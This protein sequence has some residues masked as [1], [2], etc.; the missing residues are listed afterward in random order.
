MVCISMSTRETTYKRS[1]EVKAEAVKNL[2]TLFSIHWGETSKKTP[3][4][5]ASEALIIISKA[6]DIIPL[7]KAVKES[8]RIC[9][10]VEWIE[11]NHKD[12]K[13]SKLSV[14]LIGNDMA[15]THSNILKILSTIEDKKLRTFAEGEVSNIFREATEIGEDNRKRFI[16]EVSIAFVVGALFLVFILFCGY[17][18][19][20]YNIDAFLLTIITGSL[21]AVCWAQHRLRNL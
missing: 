8:E 7:D 1:S 17:G 3:E 14:R 20:S 21:F 9:T 5:V 2:V 12:I 10:F 13:A 4:L 11:K 6:Y 19:D 16:T 15:A 18:W